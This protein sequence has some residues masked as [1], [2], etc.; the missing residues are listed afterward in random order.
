MPV[1]TS[2]GNQRVWTRVVSRNIED[3]IGLVLIEILD[4]VIRSKFL[5]GKSIEFQLIVFLNKYGCHEWI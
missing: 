5:T 1:K 4:F 2:A 3:G